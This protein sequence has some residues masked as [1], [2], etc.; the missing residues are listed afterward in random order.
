[1]QRCKDQNKARIPKVCCQWSSIATC[2]INLKLQYIRSTLV[3]RTDGKKW[4]RQYLLHLFTAS[5][6]VVPQNVASCLMFVNTY[7]H[8][9]GCAGMHKLWIRFC[10]QHN[11]LASK[12]T[13]VNI[14]WVHYNTT[15]T[16]TKENLNLGFWG[17]YFLLDVL[18]MQTRSP[19]STLRL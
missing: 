4:T 5:W 15:K 16:L 1:M 9:C 18:I 11:Y 19:D 2:W 6:H 17:N 13:Q 3:W 8:V 10:S 7:F 12:F 14:S